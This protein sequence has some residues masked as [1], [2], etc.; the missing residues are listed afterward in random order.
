MIRSLILFAL[1]TSLGALVPATGFSQQREDITP[2]GYCDQTGGRITETG[3]QQVYICCYPRKR[4]CIV[5]NVIGGYSRLILL[6]ES[7]LALQKTAE[8]TISID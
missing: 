3:Y 7:R 5:S 8:A 6:G 1:V 2:R 4:K